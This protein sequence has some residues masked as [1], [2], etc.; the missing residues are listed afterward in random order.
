[1]I[2]VLFDVKLYR[3]KLFE[4][5]TLQVN[6]KTCVSNTIR[7]AFVFVF[8]LLLQ[9]A[10]FPRSILLKWHD[11]S[12]NEDGFIVERTFTG[13][14]SN[15]W[16]V[17]AYTRSNRNRLVEIFLPGACYRVAA[18]NEYGVSAY[19]NVSQVPAT[20]GKAKRRK[21]VDVP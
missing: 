4:A 19:S 15:G 20:N 12:D 14:C 10:A 11:N 5:G 16:E 3:P 6:K 7:W 9:E 13:D 18:F 1:M 8:Y 21:S 2:R 17:I